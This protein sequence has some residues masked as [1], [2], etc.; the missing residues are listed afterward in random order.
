VDVV[1]EPISREAAD[2]ILAGRAAAGLAFADGYPT[3]FTEGSA[4]AVGA[5]GGVGPFFVIDAGEQVV[6]GEIGAAFVE[7]GTAEI[8]YAIVGPREGRGYATAAVEAV[9]RRLRHDPAAERAIA[10]TPLDRPASARV[11]EKAGFGCAGI[12]EDE[13]EGE[14][15]RVQRWELALDG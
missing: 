6:V 7:P 15:L 1:L 14:V 13:H 10:H 3:E 5:E 8:G 9:V 12:V 4:Q 11:L 2:A